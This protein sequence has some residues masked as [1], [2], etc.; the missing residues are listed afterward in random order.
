LLRLAELKNL[1]V[2]QH[3]DLST[4]GIGLEGVGFFVASP[5]FAQL[6]SLNLSGNSFGD[7]G[8]KLLAALPPHANLQRLDV[9]SVKLTK[10]A[11]DRLKKR[12]GKG[13]KL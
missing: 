5:L 1:P 11:A 13:L 8:A 9:R 4:N 7:A 10:R 3:L 6:S 12:F 2:L